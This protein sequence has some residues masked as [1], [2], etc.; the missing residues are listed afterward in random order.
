M[1]CLLAVLCVAGQVRAEEPVNIDAPLPSHPGTPLTINAHASIAELRAG[2]NQGNADA[3]FKLGYAYHKGDGV[4][5][6]DKEALAWFHKSADQGNAWAQLNIGLAYQHGWGVAKDDS[7]AVVWFRKSA[8]QNNPLG[9]SNLGFAYMNG[10][11]VAKDHAEGM[12]WISKYA[13]QTTHRH[14]DPASIQV[15]SDTHA[16]RIDVVP[17]MPEADLVQAAANGNLQRVKD[18]IQGG[19]NINMRNNAGMT[20]LMWAT[21]TGRT[22]V[23]KYL[24]QNRADTSLE[25]KSGYTALTLARM[26]HRE[27]IA[28]LIEQSPVYPSA[29]PSSS[30]SS[31]HG[32]SSGIGSFINL[33][34]VLGVWALR[35]AKKKD[36][37]KKKPDVQ[38][39]EAAP[40]FPPQKAMQEPVQ[41]PAGV[42]IQKKAQ[43]H[44]VTAVLRLSGAVFIVAGICC[45]YDLG[46]I[47]DTLGMNCPQTRM[48]FSGIIFALGLLN[49]L[50]LPPLLDKRAGLGE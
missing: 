14:I 26:H 44:L 32:T 42:V 45:Y 33:V 38:K 36:A 31:S 18:L 2:A 16:L 5:Q 17:P 21:A 27:D 34:V 43:Q 24:L 12:R 20:A 22:D 19:A 1:G 9:E 15:N 6:D 39:A 30:S 28:Q 29:A 41:A 48:I 23:V 4:P 47:A 40:A 8:E 35:F 49:Y 37:D 50:V 13:E 46:G 3:E 10:A 11:G 25:N 7:E